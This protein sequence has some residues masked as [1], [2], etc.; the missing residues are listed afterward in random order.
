MIVHGATKS[1]LTDIYAAFGNDTF[2]MALYSSSATLDGDTTAYSTTDEVT[3]TGYT[4]G[5][6]TLVSSASMMTFDGDVLVI[7]W[8]D[9]SWA[10]ASFT[11]RAGLIYNSSD[12]NKSV[13]VID[14]VDD[15]TVASDTFTFQF[16]EPTKEAAIIRGI[17]LI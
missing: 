11:A 12:S 5:G 3:G 17:R 7:D 14:F 10:S 16:P 15:Q 4:A 9:P 8:N 13:C 6:V 1:H 2:K